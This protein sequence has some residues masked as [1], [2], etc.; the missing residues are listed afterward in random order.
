[1]DYQGD[2]LDSTTADR[3]RSITACA[4]LLSGCTIAIHVGCG[5]ASPVE[6]ST[7]GQITVESSPAPTITV[8]A[9]GVS[10]VELTIE[11]GSRVRFLNLDSQGHS[12]VGGPDPSQS[13]CIQIDR[14]G[15]LAPGQSSDTFVF[16]SARTC[17][18]HDHFQLGVP[19]FEGRI[20]VR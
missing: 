20:V 9:G 13:E 5:T 4:L 12:F 16:E 6:P 1:M 17:R 18:Y 15:F 3:S 11:R 7:S 2:N 19:A 8:T 10:P 14:A